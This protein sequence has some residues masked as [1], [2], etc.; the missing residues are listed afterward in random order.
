M[1]R[2]DHRTLSPLPYIYHIF[3]YRK[4]A[5]PKQISQIRRASEENILTRTAIPQ[6][7]KN[8]TCL[9]ILIKKFF[10]SRGFT[11]KSFTVS[12]LDSGPLSKKTKEFLKICKRYR[13]SASE[14]NEPGWPVRIGRA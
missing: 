4:L 11:E 2:C 13:T 10:A 5:S 3:R 7:Y 8:S 14:G 9:S 1:P 6:K 12:R